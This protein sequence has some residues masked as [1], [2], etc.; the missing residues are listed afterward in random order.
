MRQHSSKDLCGGRS[1][2]AVPTATSRSIAL[3]GSF[4][5]K[6]RKRTDPPVRFVFDADGIKDKTREGDFLQ[7]AQF[8]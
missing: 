8:E 6:C 1:A 7:T 3:P 2:T 5:G 4:A